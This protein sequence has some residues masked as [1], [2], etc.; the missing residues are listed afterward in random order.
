MLAIGETLV[1]AVTHLDVRRDEILAAA[2]I[3]PRVAEGLARGVIK[4]HNDEPTY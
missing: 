2:E 3:V 4:V 1:R